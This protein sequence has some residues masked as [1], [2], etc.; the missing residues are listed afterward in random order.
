V[1]YID[2]TNEGMI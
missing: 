1:S 2:R